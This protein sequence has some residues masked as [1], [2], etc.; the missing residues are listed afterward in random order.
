MAGRFVWYEL[1]TTDTEAAI[2]FYS[3]VI[4]WKTE[5]FGGSMGP[6]PYTMWAG[7]QGRS[8]A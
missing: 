2:A 3:H 5:Q 8:A 7:T 4:G 6:E 1:L